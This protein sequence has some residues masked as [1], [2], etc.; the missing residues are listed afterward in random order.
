M[1]TRTTERFGV[2]STL[3]GDGWFDWLYMANLNA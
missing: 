2:A 1:L 3:R